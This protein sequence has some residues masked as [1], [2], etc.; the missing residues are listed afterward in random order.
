MRY[1]M[2]SFRSLT[3]TG[4]AVAALA[5]TLPAFA[6]TL[7]PKLQALSDAYQQSPK[8]TIARAVQAAHEQTPPRL[9][10]PHVNAAGLVQVYMHYENGAMPTHVALTQLGAS[11]VFVSRPLGV[12]QAWVPI[13]K[14]D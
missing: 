8:T 10:V 5:I 1:A 11:G 7:A 9:L 3:R 12:V 14:L 4:V 13:S 2:F 6:G